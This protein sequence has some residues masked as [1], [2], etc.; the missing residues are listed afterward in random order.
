MQDHA[1]NKHADVRMQNVMFPQIFITMGSL[2]SVDTM[3]INGFVTSV[4]VE[5]L[6]FGNSTCIPF[7][8]QNALQTELQGC[9]L[10]LNFLIDWQI[11]TTPPCLF[12]IL[13]VFL[14]ILMLF[15]FSLRFYYILHEINMLMT[16]LVGWSSLNHYLFSHQFIYMYSNK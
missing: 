2:C 6:V 11:S 5:N 14:N 16:S 3:I 10:C 1:Y 12:V 7:Y 8:M 15:W 9:W 13:T 4:Y